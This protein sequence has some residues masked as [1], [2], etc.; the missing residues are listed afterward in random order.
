VFQYVRVIDRSGSITRAD[1]PPPEFPARERG[2]RT[3]AILS[4]YHPGVLYPGALKIDAATQ[5][6]SNPFA[7]RA[8]PAS[9]IWIQTTPGWTDGGGPEFVTGIG[10]LEIEYL[11]ANGHF[12]VSAFGD[13]GNIGNNLSDSAMK[14]LPTV[15][16]QTNVLSVTVLLFAYRTWTTGTVS[17]FQWG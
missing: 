9:D 10:I 1:G 14:N 7:T 11:D 15:W 3:M 4:I 6:I 16:F 13:T 2:D 5:R 17:L 8:N 12:H